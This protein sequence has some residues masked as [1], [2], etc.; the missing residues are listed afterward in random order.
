MKGFSGI[1]TGISQV[2]GIGAPKAL[3]FDI[4]ARGAGNFTN[5]LKVGY[6]ICVSDTTFVGSQIGYGLTSI[7]T[8]EKSTVGIGTTFA[9][10]IY[11][12]SGY[13]RFDANSGIITC[14]ISNSTPNAGLTTT[15]GINTSTIGTFSWGILG[16]TGARN[17]PLGIGVTGLTYN[18][19]L[20]TF[21]T[22]QRRGFG[23]RSN[24]AL[25]KDLG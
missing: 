24:G 23:I 6:P 13:H 4:N 14:N 1:I 16:A 19:G 18:P 25:R 9:D 21:P 22:I 5:D 2:T 3:R 12:V 7:D 10:N 15:A 8:H 17:L 20:T 11:I